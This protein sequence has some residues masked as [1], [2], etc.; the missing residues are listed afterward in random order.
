MLPMVCNILLS[1]LF[2]FLC[3]DTIVIIKGLCVDDLLNLLLFVKF[4]LF[5]PC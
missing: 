4:V 5:V 1:V 2:V 3:L